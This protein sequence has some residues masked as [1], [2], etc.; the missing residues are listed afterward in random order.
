V[1]GAEALKGSD[2]AVMVVRGRWARGDVEACFG[3][4]G[5]SFAIKNFGTLAFVDDH[6]ALLTNRSDVDA[7]A[8]ATR[9]AGPGVHAL[10]MYRALPE[11][12]AIG[13]VADGASKDDWS[14]IEM[15]A[16]SDVSAWLRVQPGGVAF[17][18]SA[19]GH[20]AAAAK[21]AEQVVRP[22]IDSV[23]GKTD[24]LGKIDLARTGTVVRV[25]GTLTELMLDMLASSQ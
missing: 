12:R 15:P 18:A 17:D 5:E 7:H 10:A 9:G 25:S 4:H 14:M 6:T 21:H 2:H 19:D 24:A 11:D 23:F 8:L 20:D 1:L 16:G 3:G 13:F 22:Q